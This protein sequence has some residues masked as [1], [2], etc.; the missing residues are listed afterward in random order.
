MKQARRLGKKKRTKNWFIFTK[1]KNF[2]GNKSQKKFLGETKR[3]ATVGIEDWRLGL[4]FNGLKRTMR[5]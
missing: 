3:C 1:R 2:P 4:R 5:T